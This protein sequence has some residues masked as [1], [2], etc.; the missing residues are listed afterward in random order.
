MFYYIPNTSAKKH[1]LIPCLFW[2]FLKI[3]N[4]L[5]SNQKWPYNLQQ[6]PSRNY[7]TDHILLYLA[8]SGVIWHYSRTF[9]HLNFW[10]KFTPVT[11]QPEFPK[12]IDQLMI[13]NNTAG[14]TDFICL[15]L[16]SFVWSVLWSR[17]WLA[18]FRKHGHFQPISDHLIKSSLSG[19]LTLLAPFF[20]ILSWSID[21]HVGTLIYFVN[22]IQN[23]VE[24]NEK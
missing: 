16:T 14:D 13:L 10:P 1:S 9:D 8:T 11:L 23:F 21:V 22:F 12:S 5:T 6:L 17:C 18:P 24:K 19:P 20:V 3:G 15:V 2:S 4:H 7:T